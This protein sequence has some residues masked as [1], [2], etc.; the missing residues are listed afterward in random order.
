MSNVDDVCHLPLC[1]SL[2]DALLQSS[3][4]KNQVFS[5]HFNDAREQKQQQQKT[6]TPDIH[7]TMG[8]EFKKN[9]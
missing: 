1:N 9:D 5:P 4:S 2:N 3:P 6:L 7:C 8:N